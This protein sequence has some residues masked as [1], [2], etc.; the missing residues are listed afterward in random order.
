MLERLL[1]SPILLM[2]AIMVLV[3]IVGTA[4]DMTS[5]NLLRNCA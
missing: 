4:T 2:V 5:T 3:M 1:G